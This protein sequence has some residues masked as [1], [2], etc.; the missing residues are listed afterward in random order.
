MEIRIMS[1]TIYTRNNCVQCHAT[2]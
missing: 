2:K 1:I